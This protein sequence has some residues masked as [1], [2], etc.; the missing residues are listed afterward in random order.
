MSRDYDETAPVREPTG[1]ALW[2]VLVCVAHTLAAASVFSVMVKITP[3]FVRAWANFDAALPAMTIAMIDGSRHL[4]DYWYLYV[5]LLP[6]ELVLLSI[7]RT[8]G[9]RGRIAAE[10]F[11]I[12]LLGAT[13]FFHF[14]AFIFVTLPTEALFDRIIEQHQVEAKP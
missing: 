2:I 9:P 12:V 7:V 13:I 1:S 11:N 5:P 6:L 3:T 14:F 8:R 4:N 10:Y